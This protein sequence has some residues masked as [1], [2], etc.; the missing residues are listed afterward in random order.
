MNPTFRRT[1]ERKMHRLSPPPTQAL[2][3]GVLR[4]ASSRLRSPRVGQHC[5]TRP[6]SPRAT[7]PLLRLPRDQPRPSRTPLRRSRQAYPESARFDGTSHL[8]LAAA[9][10]VERLVAVIPRPHKNLIPYT[11][12]L[13]P[14][15]KLRAR[16]T[17]FGRPTDAIA[18]SDKT[19]RTPPHQSPNPTNSR[20]PC[21]KPTTASGP[22]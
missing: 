16:V 15:S 2:C 14:N 9:E 7:P 20:S 19:M 21:D 17:C 1:L 12:V 10:L 13:A 5:C 6:R 8:I 4:S 22:A 3:K 18:F 11:G